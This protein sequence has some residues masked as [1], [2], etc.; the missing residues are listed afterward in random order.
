MMKEIQSFFEIDDRLCALAEQAEER[1]KPV[2]AAIDQRAA[3][4]GAKVLKAFQNN[5][6]SEP[7]FYGSTGYGYGDQGREVLDKVVAE[8]FGAEDALV[9]HNFVSG[10]HALTV[11]LF[12]VLR[13]GDK[14]VSITGRPYDTLEGVIGLNGNKGD[15]SLMD[16]GVT[17][18]EVPLLEDGTPNYDAIPEAVRGAKIAYIQRSRGYALRPAFT[19][20]QIEKMAQLARSSN[21]DIIVMVDNCYGEFTDTSEPVQHG[22]DLMIGS[23]IKNVGGGIAR[24]GGYIAGRKDLVELCS[25]RLTCVGMGKEVG[26][27]LDMNRELFLGFFHAPDVTASALKTAAFAASL[28]ELLGFACYPRYDEPRN[29]IVE[30]ICLGDEAHLTAFCQGIQA[31]SPVDSF[32]VPEAWDMP[33]YTSKV[34]MAAGAFTLGASIELSADAPIREP[35]AVWMQGGITETSGKIGVLLAAQKMLENQLLPTLQC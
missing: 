16:Y 28:F 2:F 35:F 6:V 33:G 24:T 14:M 18:D 1:C 8:A 20:A 12:G 5:R 25:Y 7:C 31:G 22:A 19:L 34:I 13:T 30:A 11:A 32:V 29:D 9:R 3:Y 21:P 15:G 26:C 23:M 10:T 17:Y 4:N 27:T